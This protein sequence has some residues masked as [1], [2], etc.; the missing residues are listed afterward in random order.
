M[1]VNGQTELHLNDPQQATQTLQ[2]STEASTIQVTIGPVSVDGNSPALLSAHIT[3]A[4][5]SEKVSADVYGAIALDHAESQ[6]LRGEKGGKRLTHV[7]VVEELKKI[8]KLEKG[9]DVSLDFQTKLPPGMD[10]HNLRLVVFLQQSG[11]GKV[12]GAA[13]SRPGA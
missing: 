8:G 5:R 2:K 9:R 13:M 6:V 12:L 1:I 4:G 3:I 7:S 10:P 11:Q